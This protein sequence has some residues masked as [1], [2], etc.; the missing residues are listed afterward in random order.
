[1]IQSFNRELAQVKK[2]QEL[3]VQT[4]EKQ[5]KTWESY[6]KLGKKL[7]SQLRRHRQWLEKFRQKFISKPCL[8]IELWFC[9]NAIKMR[10]S[11]IGGK[12]QVY[13]T[14]LE[15][16]FFSWEDVQ[17]EEFSAL[18]FINCVI[19]STTSIDRLVLKKMSRKREVD[20][21]YFEKKIADW[22]K[23]L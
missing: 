18:R 1:M 10:L 8:E 9:R 12:N 19:S 5:Q 15:G 16:N 3:V 23:I 7:E 2:Y 20:V 14:R 17:N 4:S 13:K 22:R 6:L 21:A 11:M